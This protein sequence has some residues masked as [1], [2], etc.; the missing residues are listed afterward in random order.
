MARDAL[1]LFRLHLTP[2][3]YQFS[4]PRHVTNGLKNHNGGFTNMNW[5]LSN[6]GSVASSWKVLPHAVSCLECQG[7]IIDEAA[8]LIIVCL[9]LHLYM[10]ILF[11]YI[12]WKYDKC[13]VWKLCSCILIVEGRRVEGN[14]TDTACL[15]N[16]PTLHQLLNVSVCFITIYYLYHVAS[17]SCPFLIAVHLG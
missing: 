16:P 8:L 6:I 3:L 1:S 2:T 7:G 14:N 12:S 17:F 9:H 5:C 11:K 10:L 15:S 13:C 4:T